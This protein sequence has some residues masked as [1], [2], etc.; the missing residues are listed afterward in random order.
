[1]AGAEERWAGRV[2]HA[3]YRPAKWRGA[4][5]SLRSATQSSM[6]TPKVCSIAKPD[7]STGSEKALERAGIMPGCDWK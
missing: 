7:D 2:G 5:A 4:A 6:R 3:P 1:M